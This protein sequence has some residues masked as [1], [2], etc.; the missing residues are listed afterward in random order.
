MEEEDIFEMLGLPDDDDDRAYLKM[1]E[2][3]ISDSDTDEGIIDTALKKL[4]FFYSRYRDKR[5]KTSED[6]KYQDNSTTR[7]HQ[8]N[9]S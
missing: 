4:T 7:T 1:S 8:L 5:R 2:G 3:D 6:C 9:N